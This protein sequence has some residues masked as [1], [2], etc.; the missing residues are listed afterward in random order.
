MTE[1]LLKQYKNI[2]IVFAGGV[3][4]NV[5]IKEYMQNK[6]GAFFAKPKYSSDNAAGIAVLTRIRDERK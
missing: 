6:Y 4:A 1:L 3:M 5:I 2:Q